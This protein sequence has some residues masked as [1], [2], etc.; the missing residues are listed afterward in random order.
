MDALREFQQVSVMR[1]AAADISGGLPLMKVSDRLTDVAELVIQATL[2]PADGPHPGSRRVVSEDTS[3]EM[4]ALMR[5]NVVRG[6]GSRAPSGYVRRT[7]ITL[8]EMISIPT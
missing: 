7:M 1:I 8:R 3:R 5:A 2:R 6:S 4:L